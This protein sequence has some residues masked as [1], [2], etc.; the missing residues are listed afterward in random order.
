M[1]MNQDTDN[2]KEIRLNVLQKPIIF[3]EKKVNTE[4]KRCITFSYN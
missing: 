3:L 1:G 2:T 4:P